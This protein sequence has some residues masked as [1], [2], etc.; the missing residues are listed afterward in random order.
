[1]P[2]TFGVGTTGA[3]MTTEK[4]ATRAASMW[5]PGNDEPMQDERAAGLGHLFQAFRERRGLTRE[6][7]AAS[8]T[9]GLT[10]E[11]IGKIERGRTHPGRRVLDLLVD[12]LGLDVAERGAVQ[13]AWL[14]QV[15][16]E[17]D[18]GAAPPLATPVGLPPVPTSLVGREQAEASVAELLQRGEVRLL[19]LT[20]PGGV[21]KTSLALQVAASV[22]GH[23]A[24]GVV[25]VDLAPLRDA[26]LVLAYVANA[27][28]VAE[29][30]GRPL[31]ETLVGHLERRHLLLL[32]D[33]FEQVREAAGA[34]AELCGACPRLQVVV[35][36][37][38]ALRLRGEQL[39]PVSPLAVPVPGKVLGP[40]ALGRVPAVTLFVE[41][42]RARR[43]EFAL[44]VSNGSAVA[45]LCSRLDGL[46]LAIELAAARVG[47]LSP[48]ALLARMDGA[49]GVLTDGPRDLPARQRTIRDVIA[50]TYDLLDEDNHRLFRRLGVFAGG[51]TLAAVGAV[52]TAEPVG[53]DGSNDALQ[54]TSSLLDALSAL[55]EAHL[56][57]VVEAQTPA[58]ATSPAPGPSVPA[59]ALWETSAGSAPMTSSEERQLEAELSFR[60]LET[61]RAFALERLEAS[62]EATTIYRRHASYY[63]ALAEAG[64][65]ALSGPDQGAWL[66]RLEAEH[67]NLRAALGYARERADTTLGLR[68]AGA[69]W[70]FWQR[71]CH[72]GE[73]RRWLEYFLVAEGAQAA[74]PEVRA[75]ALTGAAWLAHDQDDFAPADAR[76]EEGLTLYRALGQPGHVAQVLV[77]RAVM[78]RGQGR[79]QEALALAEESLAL[80]RDA[81]DDGAIAFAL[82]RLGMVARERGE[83]AWA[84]AAFD[85]SLAFYRA[86]GD[87][88]G[89]AFALLGLG[90][91]ARDEGRAAMVEAYC[92]DSLEQCRELGRHWGTGFSLNNLAVAAAMR[93]DLERAEA[94]TTEALALFRTH[95]IRGGVVE[96]LVTSG[97]VACDRG[98]YKRARATLREGVA[99]G[100]PAG[101]HW[102][103]ATGLEELA[104][105]SLA[106]ADPRTATLLSGAADAWRQRMG[107][108]LPPYRRASVDAMLAAARHALGDEPFNGVRT[109]GELLLPEHAV[110]LA[111][112]SAIARS[113]E[114]SVSGSGFLVGN[115]SGASR[116]L[117]RLS[118]RERDVLSLVAEGKTNQTISE[119]LVLNAK[120]VDSH[121]RNIFLKLDLPATSDGHRRVL[122]VLAYLHGTR[123]AQE[124]GGR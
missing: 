34:V 3:S 31:L 98:D 72:L 118:K 65:R 41:R 47:V 97:Q 89:A 57:Q 1:M 50:W 87:R 30:G 17:A 64:T 40:E 29:Q 79:Y 106:E 14:A 110:A 117:D 38:M 51:S 33:N 82:S 93:S 91:V 24:D 10:V 56:L 42:A 121:I 49:L 124:A 45:M 12:A 59:H 35:T 43:P 67:D 114:A 32:L 100:W 108:P 75:V 102:L 58:Y 120:T 20:G 19:T 54:S 52:C 86:L 23:Y 13:A 4:Q 80:A 71:H 119:E 101:P 55:V 22:R 78:A 112:G 27:L 25:F 61:V 113:A 105:V 99:Q 9:S 123:D 8:A 116:P 94:L 11:T 83:F 26:R 84:R 88:S 39:Y 95:G 122:A 63:L 104:R 21:G 2:G 18:R 81:D 107:A 44:T 92:A 90:D 36:S 109:E 85:E 111:V 53:R 46:P 73:G 74:A 60:Q 7:L 69:L 6:A 70:P 96:L 5:R 16:T 77:H 103:V 68:L 115:R 62:G 37:R 76:F 48:A 15:T 28:A 66:A